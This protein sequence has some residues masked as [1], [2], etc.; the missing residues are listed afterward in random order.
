MAD[1]EPIPAPVAPAALRATNIEAAPSWIGA[2]RVRWRRLPLPARIVLWIVGILFAIWLILF[3]TKGRFLKTPFER[4]MSA[5]LE[6][7]VRV[8]GD[9]QLYFAPITIKFLAQDMTIA[10]LPWASRPAFF[11]AGQIDM[12]IAPLSL[13]FGDRYRVRTLDLQKAAIDL[14][15]SK[16]GNSN[17][18]TF[19]APDAKAEPLTLPLIQ[20]ALITGTTMRY[21]DPAM[22]IATDISVD[23]VKAQD[24]RFASDIRFTGAGTMRG[25]PFSMRGGLLSPNETVTGG[26]NQ[27]AVAAQA[28]ATELDIT[29]TLPGATV[30]EGADLK[31]KAS[32]P[33]ISL[34]FDYLGIVTPD[35]RAYHVTS[36]LTKVG[37]EWRF[38][39][40]K[41]RFGDSDI[42]GRMTVSLPDNRPLLKANLSTQRLDILDAGPFIGYDPERLEAQGAAG[43]ITTV[44]GQKRLLPDAPLRIEA[45]RNFDADVRY[46]VKSVRADNVPVSN[47]ALAL[48]LDH[49]LLTLSPLTF[50]MAGGHISSDIA[51]DARV[52]PVDTRYDIRLSPTPMGRLLAGWGVEESGTTGTIK[53]R[54]QMTGIGNSVHDSLAAANG[55]IAVILPAGSMW[56]RNIQL[57]EL[58][59]GTFISKMFSGKLKKPV[60]INCGLIA[61]TV[62]NGVAAADPILIDTQKNVMLGRG[63]FSFRDES[64]DL[65]F[66][67]DGKKFSLFSGQSPV[68]I[69]GHFAAPSY[70]IISPELV[71]RGG[72]AVA[73]GAVASPLASVLAFVDIG[74]AKSAACGP[75][76][77]GANAAAQRAKGGKPRNDVGRGT[78]SKKE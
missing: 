13:M 4:I 45:I 50:D 16:D 2:A 12:R 42:A 70:D 44:G 76:L 71:A 43:A 58:D 5:S 67:A 49:S 39:H 15:W 34:L 33:N 62:R 57:S 78:T 47:I 8:G 72:A 37:G 41:G 51:I 65:R 10:N 30:I 28:G 75:V 73:L 64:I 77:A 31:L 22:Q 17:T 48:K 14:E 56:A 54:V 21:R 40:I 9:F 61:F 53:A 11:Q 60:Q 46:T 25:K 36:A 74:D 7:P 18:W 32:G 68:G 3:I 26:R 23:T 55:R 6:R 19:G 69:G 35:T 27:L 38:T 29:G 66:R 20:R 59:V 63:S 24:T 1:T 52:K